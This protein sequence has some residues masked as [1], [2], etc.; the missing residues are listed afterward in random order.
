MQWP[1]AFFMKLSQVKMGDKLTQSKILR[2]AFEFAVENVITK[3]T[4]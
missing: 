1:F 2:G 4:G 3:C